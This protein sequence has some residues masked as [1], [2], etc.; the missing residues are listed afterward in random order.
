MDQRARFLDIQSALN[1]V[2]DDITWHGNILAHALFPDNNFDALYFS[3]IWNLEL[4]RKDIPAL[5]DRKSKVFDA[6]ANSMEKRYG[7]GVICGL[8]AQSY[9]Y[10]FDKGVR[11]SLERAAR[12]TSE[13]VYDVGYAYKADKKIR[14]NGDVANIKS[15]FREYRA[16][17]HVWAGALNH[18]L[19][20]EAAKHRE[21]NKAFAEIYLYYSRR[22]NDIANTTT[23]NMLPFPETG[24]R[25]SNCSFLSDGLAAALEAA[26][27]ICRGR[28]DF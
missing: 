5:R 4:E 22:L 13:V 9:I 26:F 14:L 11:P 19:I 27:K 23:W 24:G 15:I 3:L 28:G 8:V 1:G 20:D 12:L 17:A 7:R 16:Y 6:I 25:L 21:R 18:E 10:L 2:A